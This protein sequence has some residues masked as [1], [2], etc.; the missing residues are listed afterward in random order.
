MCLYCV[1]EFANVYALDSNIKIDREDVWLMV[2]VILITD[3]FLNR[4]FPGVRV[5]NLLT[6]SC[7]PLPV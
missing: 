1:L 4:F 3:I 2:K 7:H 6:M 5:A